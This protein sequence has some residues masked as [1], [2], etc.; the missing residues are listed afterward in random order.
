MRIS[1]AGERFLSPVCAG[2]DDGPRH[3]SYLSTSA[4]AIRV[5]LR[6]G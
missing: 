6:A 4:G 1:E 2:K 5:A 3:Y